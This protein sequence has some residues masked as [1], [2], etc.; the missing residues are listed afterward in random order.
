MSVLRKAASDPAFL[1]LMA[2]TGGAGVATQGA[3]LLDLVRGETH[4][5]NS[6]EIPLN[7]LITLL[8]GLPP[9]AVAMASASLDP[10]LRESLSNVMDKSI[11]N[12]LAR[13]GAKEGIS[14]EEFAKLKQLSETSKQTPEME[15]VLEKINTQAVEKGNT[16][17]LSRE[18]ILKNRLRRGGL[19]TL[20]AAGVGAV[21]AI[22]AM[23]DQPAESL[24]VI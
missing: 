8:A 22:L 7:Y 18:Q 24:P 10:V 1:A 3:G 19:A 11:A 12:D 13:K 20:G 2:G 9:A 15:R 23:K 5:L 16:Q 4:G 21:P 6:G 17:A 14:P